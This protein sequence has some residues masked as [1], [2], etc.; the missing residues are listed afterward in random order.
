MKEEFNYTDPIISKEIAELGIKWK[1][2]HYWVFIP[3][4]GVYVLKNKGQ[5]FAKAFPA[6]NM[7]ELGHII[8]FGFFNEMKI[9]KYLDGYFKVQLSDETWLTVTS[10]VEARAR[11]LIY[12]VKSGKANVTS[13]PF[14]YS[15]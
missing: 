8:P 15:K 6:Y 1:A 5:I 12:L 9:H 2:S 14:F 10:E 7:T 3:G 13:T 4:R 11:F